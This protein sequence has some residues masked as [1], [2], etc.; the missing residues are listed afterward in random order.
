MLL[1]A[2]TLACVALVYFPLTRVYFYSDDIGHLV[3]VADR[4]FAYFLLQPWA[5]H[6]Y[7]VRNFFFYAPYWLFGFRPEPYGWL[8]LGL[9]LVNT[10]LFFFA[11]RNISRSDVLGALGALLW[12]TCLL[13]SG[14]LGWFCVHGHVLA[15]TALLIALEQLTRTREEESVAPSTAALCVAVLWAGATCFGDGTGIAMAAP[16]A[17]AVL[18][19]GAYRSPRA[20]ALFLGLPVLVLG[21]YFGKLW[22]F[23][24]LYG[25][26]PL[27]DRLLLPLAFSSLRP[28]VE[29]LGNLVRVGIAGVTWSFAFVPNRDPAGPAWGTLALYV[30]LISGAT[31]IGSGRAR[32]QIAGLLI[33]AASAYGSIALGRANLFSRVL[34][35]SDLSDVS[36]A[37]R[38]HYLG[39]IPIAML[40][41]ASL[42]QFAQRTRL[43]RIVPG[44]SLALYGTVGAYLFSKKQWNIDEHAPCRE[45]FVASLKRIDAEIDAHPPGTDVYLQN[46]PALQCF[47]PDADRSADLFVLVYP[48][49]QVRGRRVHFQTTD[50][51]LLTRTA[52]SQHRFSTLL[53]AAPETPPPAHSPRADIVKTA[54]A[55]CGQLKL[56]HD[57][58]RAT[59]A[60]PRDDWA[61]WET[62]CGRLYPGPGCSEEIASLL[63]CMEGAKSGWSCDETGGLELARNACPEQFNVLF[64]CGS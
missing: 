20:R 42:A 13:G 52:G 56:L 28:T 7:I 11:A 18:V 24:H 10:A 53:V 12:G 26:V 1:L 23:G 30:L 17:I 15:G 31:V 3:Q 49:N 19:P 38:Y 55:A 6:L 46:E 34:G 37:D 29:M 32:R 62:T 2:L 27:R 44:L 21:T 16:L 47:S 61:R 36:K 54:N 39:T 14:S 57:R 25:G 33:L 63:D 45:S 50:R 4:G 9:Q 60:C 64:D 22:L 58:M 48:Q 51:A 35:V 43:P 59:L 40:L 41:V 5:G 8:G